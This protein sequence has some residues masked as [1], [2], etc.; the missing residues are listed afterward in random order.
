MSNAADR[1]DAQ[2]SKAL[3]RLG[4]WPENWV[5][6]QAGIDHDVVIVGGG[7]TCVTFACALRRAGIANFTVIDAAENEAQSGVWLTRARMKKLRTPKTLSGPELGVPELSFRAWYEANHGEEAYAAIDRIPRTAWAA[8]LDW[9]RRILAIPVRYRTRLR[10]IEPADGHFR[11]HLTEDGVDKVETARKIILGNGV[12]GNGAPYLPPVLTD[13]LPHELYAHTA[14]AIDFDALRRKTV[15]VVGGAASAF[16]AAAT[17]LETDAAHVHLFAR[18]PEIAAVPVIRPRIY[19][20]AIA[21]YH[22]LPDADRWRLARSYYQAGSTPPADAIERVLVFANFHLHLNAPWTAA[23]VD[24]GRVAA[25]VGGERLHFDFV[26]AGTGY[27]V[28]VKARP[29][30]SRFADQ[31]ALWAD[32]YT[33]PA[34]EADES[35]GRHPYLGAGYEYTE[36]VPG[37]A[38]FLKNIHVFNPA[39]FVSFGLPVGDVPSIPY[40]VPRIVRRISRDLF[41]ADLDAHRHRFDGDVPTDFTRDLYASAVWSNGETIAAE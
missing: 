26:I 36:K 21:N 3:S 40:G 39:G 12:A 35:L 37:A 30:L 8:Y 11:L 38:P 23:Q 31:I 32:R 5:P 7:H 14:D 15:A 28:D 24:N 1:A 27:A 4:A 19:P 20:G 22:E 29:E 2:A 33:P 18:R 41:L 13:Q 10:E 25:S 16:D 34:G 9:Y 6:P 17:A